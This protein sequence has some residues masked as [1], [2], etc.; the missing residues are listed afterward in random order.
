MRDFRQAGVV[1]FEKVATDGDVGRCPTSH[2]SFQPSGLSPFH[3]ARPPQSEPA[4]AQND[5][6]FAPR[7]TR[8]PRGRR[9]YPDEDLSDP[10]RS[11]WWLVKGRMRTKAGT[12]LQSGPLSLG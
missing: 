7:A 9:T 1:R 6:P 10:F 3:P 8:K 12:T 5:D 11:A 4:S 2:A